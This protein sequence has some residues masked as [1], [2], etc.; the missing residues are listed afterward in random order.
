MRKAAT[1]TSSLKYDITI[2]FL[3]PNSLKDENILAICIHLRYIPWSIKNVPLYYG[4]YLPHFLMD[5]NTLCT[6]K[7]RKKYSIGSY[8]ICNITT[9]VSLHYLRKFKNTQNSMIMGDGFLPYV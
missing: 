1:S 8:K 4:P 9:T 2:V 6:N 7:N 5:F 3:H